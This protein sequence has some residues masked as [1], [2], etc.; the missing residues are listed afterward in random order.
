M[1]MTRRFGPSFVLNR[2]DNLIVLEYRFRT[3]L[4][5]PVALSIL[6]LRS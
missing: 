5:S 6:R 4:T 2:A 1:A 3:N